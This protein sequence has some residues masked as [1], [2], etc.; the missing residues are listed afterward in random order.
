MI[1]V[2]GKTLLVEAFGRGVEGQCVY[3]GGVRI[4]ANVAEAPN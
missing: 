4:R 3:D 2:F 1:N